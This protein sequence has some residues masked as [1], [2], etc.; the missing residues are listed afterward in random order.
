MSL[1]I[2]HESPA[3]RV[4]ICDVTRAAFLKAAHA[5]HTEHLI[6]DALR[7]AGALSLSLVA[8]TSDD[9]IGHVAVSPVTISRGAKG[10]FGLGPLSVLPAYQGHGIGSLL[11][12]EAL[13][14][15]RQRAAAGCV[16]LGEPSF[17]SR[18]GF[19]READLV[20]PGVPPEYFQAICLYGAVPRGDVR[21][22]DAFN[23]TG[24]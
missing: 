2:R 13:S 5:S 9:I 6:V 15:L 11:V 4:A 7:Q 14:V 8:E 17:Y 19:K 16:V 22:H 24:E 21:Y 18:F 10:W 23:A 3:D 1:A 12:Q 20:L